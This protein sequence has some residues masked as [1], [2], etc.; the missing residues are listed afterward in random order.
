MGARAGDDQRLRPHR[1]VV[2]VDQCTAAGGVRGAADRVA[3]VGGGVVCAG[4]VVARGAG[5]GGRRVVCGRPWR[6][7]W[8]S[9]PGPV[10]GVEICS[11]PVWRRDIPRDKDV[12]HRGPGVL[13]TRRAADLPGPRRRAGEDPRVSH[14]AR[15]RA[16]GVGR[17]GRGG[18][19]GRDRPRGPPRQQAPGGLCHRRRGTFWDACRA[20]RAAAGLHGAGRGGGVGSAAVD[21]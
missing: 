11:V 19:G 18:A 12:S 17:A 16:R 14:R 6:R 4:S 1:D 20:G 2:R 3:G 7:G 10:D 21:A 13:A 5:R 15:G 8:L 9:G